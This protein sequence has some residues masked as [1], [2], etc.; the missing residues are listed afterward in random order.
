M[1]PTKRFKPSDT[2]IVSFNS[3]WLGYVNNPTIEEIEMFKAS[4]TNTFIDLHNGETI[5]IISV[6]GVWNSYKV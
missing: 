6:D 1:K 4:K 5:E 2:K 3:A